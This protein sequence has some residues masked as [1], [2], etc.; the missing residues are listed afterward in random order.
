M[1]F[2]KLS[3][4]G[5]EKLLLNTNN[6]LYIKPSDIGTLI[7]TNVPI[8]YGVNNTNSNIIIVDES[9]DKVKSMLAQ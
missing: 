7:K 9:Y 3:Q 5:G 6:I 4:R 8:K 2:V 1:K